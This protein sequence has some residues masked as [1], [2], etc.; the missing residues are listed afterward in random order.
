VTAPRVPTY[1]VF[2]AFCPAASLLG[3]GLPAIGLDAA[4]RVLGVDLY[5]RA[6][7]DVALVGLRVDA[8]VGTESFLASLRHAAAAAG[9]SVLEPARLPPADRDRFY[10]DH[11]A[12][13][14]FKVENFP[15]VAD[16]AR[17]LAVD[18]G[19]DA[20][21][22]AASSA[23]PL[24]AMRWRA[25]DRWQLA[26]AR[27]LTREGFYAYSSAPPR[28]GE[29]VTVAL[30]AGAAQ[31]TLRATVVHVTPDDAAVTVGGPG[32][33]A[34]FNLDRVEERQALERIV[35]AGR[36]EGLGTLRPAPARREARFAVRWP[37][38]ADET[39][40]AVALDLSR[41][42]L[43]V[44]GHAAAPGARVALRITVD[45]GG[46][47]LVASGRVARVLSPVDAQ[48]RGLTAGVGLEV[49]SFAAGDAARYTALVARVE[50]RSQK[51]VLAGSTTARQLAVTAPLSAAG[52]VVT[53]V[54]RPSDLG[55]LVTRGRPDLVV[56]DR[57]FPAVARDVP[58]LALDPGQDETIVRA[59]D[60]ALI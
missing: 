12:Q 46:P 55:D 40:E 8:R 4:A 20:P 15:T 17:K 14:R 53:G 39:V 7:T 5:Y 1:D 13:Y 37:L 3:P 42:G 38:V 6:E 29:T 49:E 59:V 35:V 47:P 25:G 54:T 52:Y 45:D 11:L 28:A 21:R 23:S 36:S 22:A 60:T 34:R 10:A 48:A 27:T 51:R 26:R 30:E 41:H 33:G 32:F 57:G 24:V 56:V 43:F 2:L 9:V 50:K 44:A 18:L 31:V 19:A 58:S 16:A